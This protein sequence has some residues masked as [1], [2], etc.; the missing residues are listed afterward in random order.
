MFLRDV[1]T[2]L[3]E[4]L[5]Q[6]TDKFTE[7]VDISSSS[8]SGG[9]VTIV[10]SS[11]H[12]LETDDVIN[13][14]NCQEKVPISN[15][16]T[17]DDI[18]TITTTIDHD[19][20]LDFQDKADQPQIEIIES[21]ITAYNGKFDLLS[22]PSRKTFTISVLGLPATASDGFLLRDSFKGY[23]GLKTV[24]VIDANTFTFTTTKTTITDNGNGGIIHKGIRVSGGVDINRS[25]NAYSKQASNDFWL[26]IVPESTTSSKS[27]QTESDA[28]DQN[29]K[30]DAFRQKTLPILDIY[31]FI[32]TS[33]KF[34]G[35]AAYDSAIE[36]SVG[37][38]RSLLGWRVPSPYSITE[39]ASMI[40]ESHQPF[41]Y[42]TA[43]YIHRFQFSTL[44]EVICADIFVEKGD[45]A[46]KDIDMNMSID[47]GTENTQTLIKLDQ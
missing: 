38:F 10:T 7:Q 17:L 30:G 15:I 22:I 41:L 32:P 23:S 25:I 29:V 33:D 40:F 46:F 20:T 26:M 14:V 13:I 24:T 18:A 2:Q 28:T 37:L 43:Y 44:Q 6:Y 39:Y 47:S 42:N 27:R 36:E 19:L 21:T 35:R 1:I 4:E 34:S 8:F 3:R 12:G 11:A 9:V 31:M 16:T 5:P 45:V